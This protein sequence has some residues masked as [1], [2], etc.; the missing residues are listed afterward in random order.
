[1][2]KFKQ[3]EQ[4]VRPRTEKACHD[5]NVTATAINYHGL[6]H[7]WQAGVT[8]AIGCHGPHTA[9]FRPKRAQRNPKNV[10]TTISSTLTRCCHID[11]SGNI[12]WQPEICR[13]NQLWQNWTMPPY[14]TWEE[15]AKSKKNHG[16]DNCS[17][18]TAAANNY[19]G[20]ATTNTGL[21]LIVCRVFATYLSWRQTGPLGLTWGETV[22]L[23]KI[24]SAAMATVI[25]FQR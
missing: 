23:G 18:T 10:S 6:D 5:S 14:L 2:S 16:Q 7:H 25:D 1:M 20:V 8:I 11:H 24:T 9:R 13:G 19:C 15:P 22:I 3:K 4:N 17:G 21:T 12:N